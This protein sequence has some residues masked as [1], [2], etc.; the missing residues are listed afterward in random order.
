MGEL[1]QFAQEEFSKMFS[2]I[3]ESFEQRSTVAPE[4][5]IKGAVMFVVL[6]LGYIIV[7]PILAKVLH[8]I[9]LE[10]KRDIALSKGHVIEAK[11]VK[12]SLIGDAPKYDYIAMYDYV[13]DNQT[14]RYRAYFKYPTEPRCIL[15][16]YYINDPCK[17]FTDE[18]SHGSR[19][20]V[21]VLLFLVVPWIL[22]GIVYYL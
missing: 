16:L 21:L 14:R 7:I 22:A 9:S 6:I 19:K 20:G 15:H 5:G 11:L 8:I 2:I 13:I 17:L 1:W 10:R 18:D 3:N 12:Q 4:N